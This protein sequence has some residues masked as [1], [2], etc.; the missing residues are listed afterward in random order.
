[1]LSMPYKGLGAFSKGFLPTLLCKCNK[2]PPKKNCNSRRGICFYGLV[3]Y[4]KF[5]K[6]RLGPRFFFSFAF[7]VFLYTSPVLHYP[8]SGENC[9]ELQLYRPIMLTVISIYNSDVHRRLKEFYFFQIF[10]LSGWVTGMFHSLSPVM[11][12]WCCLVHFTQR[13]IKYGKIPRAV[14]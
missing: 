4:F 11:T 10:R 2:T 6:L 7:W 9:Y 14:G 5:Q 3:F 12:D 8:C 13:S 1:M